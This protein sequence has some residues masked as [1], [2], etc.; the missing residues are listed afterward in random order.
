MPNG[1]KKPWLNG[2]SY[3]KPRDLKSEPNQRCDPIEVYYIES[4]L[5]R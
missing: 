5:G 2:I 1:H 4:L 3:R